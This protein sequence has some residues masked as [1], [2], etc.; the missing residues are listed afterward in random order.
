[1][2]FQSIYFHYSSLKNYLIL[3]AKQNKSS[4]NLKQDSE[5]SHVLNRVEV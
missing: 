1:M 4:Q 5:M 3:Y 2:F